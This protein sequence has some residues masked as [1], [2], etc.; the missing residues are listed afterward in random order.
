MHLRFSSSLLCLLLFPLIPA[1]ADPPRTDAY[2]DPLFEG[3]IGRLGT[4]RFRHGSTTRA[5]AFAANDKVL[6][7]GGGYGVGLCLWEAATGRPL[8]RLTNPFYVSDVAVAPSGKTL[9]TSGGGNLIVGEVAT[10][11]E[12][13]RVPANGAVFMH[14]AFAPHG[15]V[16]AAARNGN[17]D[18]VVILWEAETGKELRRLEGHAKSVVSVQFSPDGKLL[19]TASFDK[20]VR[21]WD[22]ATGKEMQPLSVAET[23]VYAAA[24]VLDGQVI[25]TL[26]Y[27]DVVHLWDRPTGKLLRSLKSDG[28]GLDLFV[29]SPNGK[30]LVAAGKNGRIYLWDAATGK[31]LRRW[32]A[33]NLPVA[34][35][36]FSADGKRLATAGVRE[37]AI[38]V[39]DTAIGKALHPTPGHTGAIG[40]LKFAPDGK[41]LYSFGEDRKV[42]RWDLT[43]GLESK[44]PFGGLVVAEGMESLMVAPDLSP[45]GKTLA[46]TSWKP[47]GKSSGHAVHLWDTEHMKVL[48]TLK[49]TTAVDATLRFSPDGR[50]LASSGENGVQIWEVATGKEV[51]RLPEAFSVWGVDFSPDGALLAYAASDKKIRLWSMAT[52]KEV[53]RWETQHDVILCLVFSPDGKTLATVAERAIL[54]VW[55]T[56]TGEELR[57]FQVPGLIERAVISHSGR[58]LATVARNVHSV[59]NRIVENNT[60]YLWDIVTGE[61]IRQIETGQGWSKAIAFAPDDRTLASGGGDSTILLWD[62]TGGAMPRQ[63]TAV[64]L[65]KLWADLGGSAAK[66]DRAL[67]TLAKAPQHSVP[68][69]KERLGPKKAADP[70]VLARLLGDLESPTFKV[71]DQAT[72]ALEEMG[73]AAEEALQRTLATNPALE[74]RQRLQQLLDKRGKEIVRQ[75]RAIEALEQAGTVEATEVLEALAKT[76][77][78]PRVVFAANGANKRLASGGR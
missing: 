40:M 32:Q 38:Q 59:G 28:E 23:G 20:F 43:T 1:A 24:F 6:V 19:L 57:S 78:S 51:H 48:H 60:I 9:A 63:L 17:G 72:R 37:H 10:A 34:C 42:L 4:M 47:G 44:Q 53:H 54:Q 49:G 14:I 27:A 30:S 52:N 13:W 65:E 33:G 70:K 35:L 46:W 12:R 74:L 67:W 5:L 71:R 16:L 77:R 7:S 41:A 31:E 11:K 29:I 3:A 18:P 66:A 56:D 2:G 75:L 73:E 76:S 45:D 21:F 69:L 61:E 8:Y 62:M 26:D 55:G 50:K 15:N 36:T 39:W 64:E 68:F 22:V 25:A 58:I